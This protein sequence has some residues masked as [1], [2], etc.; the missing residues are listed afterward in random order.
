MEYVA[1]FIFDGDDTGWKDFNPGRFATSIFVRVHHPF[2][3]LARIEGPEDFANRVILTRR[4]KNLIV[5]RSSA[6]FPNHK[7]GLN[8]FMLPF[9]LE[10]S[11]DHVRVLKALLLGRPKMSGRHRAIVVKD[12][13][14]YTTG[15]ASKLHRLIGRCSRDTAF[16]QLSVTGYSWTIAHIANPFPN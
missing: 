8:R 2:C 14:G 6:R 12:G 11:D 13:H 4:V 9:L 7:H 16:G 1:S 3:F 15:D 10:L 5:I